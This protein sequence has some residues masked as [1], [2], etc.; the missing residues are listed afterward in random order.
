MSAP[1]DAVRRAVHEVPDPE[2]PFLTIGDLG[3]VR[4]VRLPETSDG[5][6]EIDITPTY[7]GCPATEAIADAVA[8]AVRAV[9]HAHVRVRSVL[10]P[11]WSTDWI[12]DTGR[13][14]LREAGISPPGPAGTVGLGLP[15]ACPRCGS[16]LTRELSF[17][18]STACQARYVCGACLEPFDHVKPL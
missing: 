5:T 10:A 13:D 1:V 3:I 2:L 18:G 14:K 15:P 12:S 4:D 17:F 16:A 9:G 7:T 8:D 6:V 11:A